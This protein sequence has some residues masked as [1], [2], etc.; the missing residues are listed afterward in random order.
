MPGVSTPM[1]QII[2]PKKRSREE[3]TSPPSTPRSPA[4]SE[5]E[6]SDTPTLKLD[7]ITS[8][9]SDPAEPL[10]SPPESDPHTLIT[11]PDHR[12]ASPPPLPALKAVVTRRSDPGVQL[13]RE[14]EAVIEEPD[15]KPTSEEPPALW[16]E[17]SKNWAVIFS[18]LESRDREESYRAV[19]KIEA[20]PAVLARLKAIFPGRLDVDRYQW[21]VERLP[22]VDQHGPVLAALA[23]IG[24]KAAPFLLELLDASSLEIRFYATF[25]IASDPTPEATSKLIP[26]LFD[27]DIQTRQ[28]ASR[29]IL[30]L[31]RTP[32]PHFESEAIKPL[33]KTVLEQ[34]DEFHVEIAA[35]LLGELRHSGAIEPLIHVLDRHRDRV[36]HTIHEA[37]TRITLQALPAATISWRTWHR[38]ALGESRELWLVQ[39]LDSPSE[40]IRRYAASELATLSGF[41]SAYSPDAPPAMRQRTQQQLSAWF[42]ARAQRS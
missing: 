19:P 21:P 13:T 32:S 24:P 5:N 20:H 25:L 7:A 34:S 36:R 16:A 35:E 11:R 39:A 8:Q 1:A 31:G 42:Q 12:A 33:G 26:R 10:S 28:L 40:K 14:L 4:T 6:P 3:D 27:R 22:P 29:A 37:L 30:E 23:R 38:G 15:L 41:H 9:R 18:Q 17:P 2:R